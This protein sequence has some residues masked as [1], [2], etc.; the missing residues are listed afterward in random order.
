MRERR[1]KGGTATI[2]VLADSFWAHGTRVACSF[3]TLWQKMRLHA[4]GLH[5]V[6]IHSFNT[7]FLSAYDVARPVVNK[8]GLAPALRELTVLVQP[9]RGQMLL[10][11][12]L[13]S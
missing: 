6:F 10:I 12:L 3:G 9:G 1:S 5:G 2:L 8:T 13:D 11:L 7:H 4:P